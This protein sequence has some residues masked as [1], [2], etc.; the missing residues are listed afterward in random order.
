MHPAEP[1]GVSRRDWLWQL[2]RRIGWHRAGLAA[3]RRRPAAGRRTAA[4]QSAGRAR[5]AF[6][7]AG[8]ARHRAVLCRCRQP[9]R[10]L[11]L[12]AGTGQAG[13]HSLRFDRQAR[14]LRLQA[15]Q[16]RAELLAV[17]PAWPKRPL[18]QRSVSAPGHLR[19]RHGLHLFDAIEKRRPCA[20]HVHDE[21]RF[22]PA[23]LS[24]HGSLDVV[25]IGERERRL[26]G[27]CR[28]CPTRAAC[29]PADRSNWNSGF[30]PAVFQATACRSEPGKPPIADL[31]PPDP[32]S[33]AAV[34]TRPARGSSWPA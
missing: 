25:W 33:A 27:L 29:R 28:A 5:P 4:R 30:L 6:R 17:S 14:I 12:Q 24:L 31:F 10:H 9:G 15:G 18:D 1:R 11:R 2:R 21:H 23:R 22:H 20:G 32:A 26:A 19:R 8:K 13:R 34:P 3:G 7:P 16:L